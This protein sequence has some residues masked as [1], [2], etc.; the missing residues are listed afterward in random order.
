[1]GSL[2]FIHEG[3]RTAQIPSAG[4]QNLRGTNL[5]PPFLGLL[6]SLAVLGL[7]SRSSEWGNHLY[8]APSATRSEPCNGKNPLVC[9]YWFPPQPLF[10]VF[11]VVSPSLVLFPLRGCH[12][13]SLSQTLMCVPLV[14]AEGWAC[15]HEEK[16]KSTLP[17]LPS[18]IF[19]LLEWELIFSW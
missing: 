5:P 16:S 7:F 19:G 11:Y 13:L 17:P 2:Q 12:S 8:R 10:L 14:L 18:H 6:L 9:V 15:A 3:A 4:R 1:M